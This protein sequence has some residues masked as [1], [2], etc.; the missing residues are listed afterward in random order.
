MEY[1]EELYEYEDDINEEENKDIKAGLAS[2]SISLMVHLFVLFIVSSVYLYTSID[3]E[4]PPV[5]LTYIDPPEV[6]EETKL[7]E[8]VQLE[9]VEV[10]IEIEEEKINEKILVSELE[11][12]EELNETE[13]DV[14]EDPDVKGREDAISNSETGGQTAFMASIGAGSSASGV[15]GRS[16]GGNKR[17]LAQGYGRNARRAHSA[18]DRSLRWLV[19]HQSPDGRW[20]SDD[21]WANC[22]LGNKCEPGQDRQ[23]ADEAITGYAILC[24]LG[25]GYDHRTPNKYRKTV[26]KGLDWLL[27]VQDDK[28]LIG[29]RN[30]EHPIATMALAEAYAMTIDPNLKLKT[31]KAVDIILERQGKKDDYPLGWNYVT[32]TIERIDASVSGWNVMA[33]KAALAG[34]LDVGNGLEGARLYISEAWKDTNPEWEKISPY[35]R[36]GFP[37]TW[38]SVT[39][40]IER[41]NLSFVG[42]L[43]SVFLS[44]HDIML[45]TMMNDVDARY[46]DTDKYKTNSYALYYASLSAFQVGRNHWTEKWGHPERGYVPWLIETMITDASCQDG[47]WPHN[48]ESWHGAETS[49]V[50]IHTYKTLA[51]EVAVRYKRITH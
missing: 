33:L 8:N 39:G 5:K 15:F 14:L 27:S 7:I 49:H 31:Q 26:K 20:D 46:F 40:E 18:I 19:R 34:G 13:D 38:N 16:Q 12:I 17:S 42:T 22:Q 47:T 32:P 3:V 44:K 21:Y 23:G 35:D 36:S 4:R 28:G 37:Y 25:A 41:D 11:E 30:Y 51:L 24:F 48:K 6:V 10:E 29:K 9:E 1:E 43:C 50:L 2:W 45:D